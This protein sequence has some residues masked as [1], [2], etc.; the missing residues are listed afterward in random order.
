MTNF[1]NIFL[2]FFPS[3]KRATISGADRL[4][5]TPEKQLNKG[6]TLVS[7]NTVDDIADYI[8]TQLPQGVQSVV[9][10][11][12]IMVDNT[13]PQN[14]IVS[15]SGG[16]SLWAEGDP[17]GGSDDYLYNVNQD[18][19][20]GFIVY[21]TDGTVTS[22]IAILNDTD[23]ITLNTQDGITETTFSLQPTGVRISTDATVPNIILTLPEY[24]DDTAADADGNLNQGALYKLIGDRTLYQKP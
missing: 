23:R 10:G 18:L 15:S 9:A 19:T 1:W 3:K 13:D 8:S 21:K 24:A 16:S 4:V 7:Y 17:F 22:L 12:N 6:N 5:L 11:T 20:Q 14:P 2:K